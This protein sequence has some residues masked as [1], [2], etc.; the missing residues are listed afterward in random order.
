MIRTASL[1]FVLGLVSTIAI[2]QER[3]V[4]VSDSAILMPW[5]LSADAVEDMNVMN[6]QGQKV[7]EVEEVIGTNEATPTA[8]A[9]D[10]EGNGGYADRDVMIPLSNFDAGST[11]LA[12]NADMA[13]VTAMATWDD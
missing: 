6:L 5:N 3:L 7:G 12:L 11:G 8:L 13:Q 2:A 10:F 4:K 1:T 9:I